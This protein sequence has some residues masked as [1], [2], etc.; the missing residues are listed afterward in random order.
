MTA[1]WTNEDIGAILQQ[2]NE[3]KLPFKKYVFSGID[4]GLHILGRGAT[5]NVYKAE[6]RDKH[7]EGY[8]IKVIGF[9]DKNADPDSFRKST[10]LQTDLGLFKDN[11]VK[12]FDS[13]ELRVWIEGEH[14]VTKAE[15]VDPYDD[16]EVS[17]EYLRLQFVL[18]EELAAVV[19]DNRFGKPSLISRLNTYDEKEI[20]NLAYDIG[21]ALRDAHEKKLIHR[22]VKLENIF[23]TAKGGGHY[24]LGDFGIARTTDNGLASTVAFTRGYGAPEVVGTLEDKYDYTADI[25]SFGMVLYLLLNELRFPES[26]NYHPNPMQ[27][28][29]GYVPEP[30]VHGSDELRRIVLRMLSFDPDDRYQSMDEVLNELDGLKYGRSLKY[31]REH[32]SLSLVLGVAFALIGA[33]CWKLSYAPDL[34]LEMNVWMYLFWGL[35]VFRAFLSAANKKTGIVSTG[36]LAIG[37]Y[38]LVSTG[39]SISKTIIMVIMVCFEGLLTGIAGGA[40]LLMNATYLIMQMTEHRSDFLSLR[41]ITFLMLYLAAFMLYQY[42][43]LK[44]RDPEITKSNFNKNVYWG[45]VALFYLNHVLVAIVAYLSKKPGKIDFFKGPV[46][47]AIYS[48]IISYNPLMIGI[49]GLIFCLIWVGREKLLMFIEDKQEKAELENEYYQ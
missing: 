49:G 27:Y 4:D 28:M 33:V 5:A 14:T 29:Y 24:K 3:L 15:R 42:N 34:K 46:G 11:V 12:I 19:K 21:T 18:M 13:I 37:I 20:L 30:P 1:D 16:K 39:V 48:V 40:M 22:D 6:M 25:Y 23:Y 44:E 8:A 7:K 35:F 38:L 47:E 31:R 36:I 43:M 2:L 41:W 17:G 45:I 26:N 10:A 32:K 9:G